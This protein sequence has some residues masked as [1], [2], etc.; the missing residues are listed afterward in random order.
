M[1]NLIC[2]FSNSA[3]RE[4]IYPSSIKNP[5]CVYLPRVENNQIQEYVHIDETIITKFVY[6]I[7]MNKIYRGS[8]NAEEKRDGFIKWINNFEGLNKSNWLVII[9]KMYKKNILN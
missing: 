2:V 3:L 7:Y 9:N 5:Y 1:E 4:N 6:E 8:N